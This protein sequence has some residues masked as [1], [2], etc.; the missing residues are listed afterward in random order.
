ME[1]RCLSSC[2]AQIE[3][4]PP[5]FFLLTRRVPAQ[6]FS[7]GNRALRAGATEVA[8]SGI[9]TMPIVPPRDFFSVV[10]FYTE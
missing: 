8:F 6:E 4:T 3:G 7:H 5:L 10:V 1:I 9:D 2:G